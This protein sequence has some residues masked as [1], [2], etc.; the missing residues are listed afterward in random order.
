MP[1]IWDTTLR[2]GSH[3]IRHQFTVAQAAGI[4]G[5]LAR[6]GATLIEVG[7][8]DGINGSSCQYGFARETDEALLKAAV[9]QAGGARVGTLA[10]PGIARGEHIRQAHGAG[11]TALRVAVH[12]T[13]A[14]QAEGFLRLANRLEMM[15]VGFLMSAHM[16]TPEELAR[17]AGILHQAGAQVVY[18]ADSAG[19]MTPDDVTRAIQ[20]V[21]T[22]APCQAGFHAHNSLGLANANALA[23]LKAGAAY[24]D[25]SLC[26]LGAGAG[27]C[28]HE[29]LA[30]A[31][32]RAGYAT[33]ED[34]FQ[35]MDV[36]DGWVQPLNTPVRLDADSITLGYC[37]TYSSFLLHARRAAEQAGVS[38]RAILQELGRMGALGGQEDLIPLA[39]QRLKNRE[40][41]VAAC[42]K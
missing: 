35:L 14:R 39:I 40:Q 18:L 23:A 37:G 38:S 34:A 8:G 33:G 13:Q 22:G 36:A 6:A 31:L 16:A 19:A 2:D 27:N 24:V 32:E 30:A 10:I 20:A 1:K 9:S 26:G 41:G 15:T 28:C 11:A 42:E 21:L 3:A 5:G 29:A 4:A 25:A 7:H 12:C 17:Q